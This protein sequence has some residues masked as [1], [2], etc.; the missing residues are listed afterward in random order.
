MTSAL[1]A[2]V[3]CVTTGLEAGRAAIPAVAGDVATS[4]GHGVLWS[5]IFSEKRH[6]WESFWTQLSDIM[7][8]ITTMSAHVASTTIVPCR[9]IKNLYKPMDAR[10]MPNLP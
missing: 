1:S 6:P 2:N 3:G 10:T 5:L 8:V 7:P 9:R 4:L